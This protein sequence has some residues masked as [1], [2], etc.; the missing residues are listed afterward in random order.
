MNRTCH[1]QATLTAAGKRPF[2][3]GSP[4]SNPQIAIW[5]TVTSQDINIKC[6]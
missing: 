5:N 1:K 3:A 2:A 6:R 4:R